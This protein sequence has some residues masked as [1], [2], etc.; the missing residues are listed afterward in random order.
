MRHPNLAERSDSCLVIVDMQEPFLQ[1][2]FDRTMVEQGVQKLVS[3][4]NIL[5]IPTLATVQNK[6]RMGDT[7]SSILEHIPSVEAVEKMSFSCCGDDVF[8]R[9]LES[10]GKRTVIL[11]GVETHIC[12][13][14]TALDLLGDGYKVHVPADAVNSRTQ[15]NW[16]VG[17]DKMSGAGVIIT[18]V[19]TV[20]F[21]LLGSAG[22]DEFRQ[23]LKIVK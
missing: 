8:K 22:T 1:S 3:A 21:E 13:N 9:Q 6:K 19:E 16:R 20:I 11:C 17:L 18:S 12:V 15:G 4:A 14:Q 2:M 23:I 5:G 7:V 10:L